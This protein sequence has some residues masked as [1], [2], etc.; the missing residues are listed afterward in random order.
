MSAPGA[1]ELRRLLAW[2]PSGGIL[3]VS[4][5][6][7]HADRGGG[8]RVALEEALK[9]VIDATR[10]DPHDVKIAVRAAA[11]EVLERFQGS[12]PP[13]GRGQI[14]YVEV[15]RKRGRAQ[16]SSYRLPPHRTEAIH[17]HR[18]YLR[19][20]I[21]IADVGAAMGVVAV[22]GDQA[23]MWEWELG[24]LSELEDW[25]LT[26]TGDWRERKAQR[27]SDPARF[28]G[29]GA[30]G[31]ERHDQRLEAH[32][33]RFLKQVAGRAASEAGERRWRDVLVFGEVEHVRPLVEGLG[34][35]E[36]RHVYKK[37]VFWEPTTE[38]ARRVEGLVPGLNREREMELV[39]T[40]KE[41]A[42]SGKERAS[43]GP[44]ET[45]EALSQGRV[46]HLL[47]D[48]ERDYRGQGIEE[49]LAY[50]GPPL[51]DDGLPIAELMI[52]RAVETGA[53][54]TPLE[55]DAAAGLEEH[56]GVAA[57]LRY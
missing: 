54:T 8:W 19:P 21:E 24:E 30:S 55:G 7:D 11:D 18:P 33:E 28:R 44:Q 15:A 52:E 46:A 27:P 10:D 35:R 17:G 9:P 42:Y 39:A 13:Q 4:M 45:L 32:R 53:R 22:S 23:R 40:V 16:W 6:I 14:G 26:P 1:D 25:T 38:I 2:E 31:R 56:A 36:S 47:F 34:S 20:L 37:N 49:G 48:A 3:S 5:V 57:L 50:E 43:L 51:G 12:S 41:S 29:A